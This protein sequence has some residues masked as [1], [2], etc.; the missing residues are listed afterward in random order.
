MPRKSQKAS[1]PAT[2][3]AEQ[4]AGRRI[5]SPW[6]RHLRAASEPYVRDKIRGLPKELRQELERRIED[7]DFRN[8]AELQSWLRA[9]GFHISRQTIT[10]YSKRFEA[11]LEALRIATAQ[12][13]AVVE[14]LKGDGAD[15][16]EAILRLV[17]GEMFN[18][19]SS[20]H[21]TRLE[22]AQLW[23]LSRTAKGIVETKILFKKWREESRAKLKAGV[24]A[25]ER[26]VAEA[27]GKGLSPEAAEEI[28]K[29]LLEI[30]V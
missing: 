24:G 2:Q 10:S 22:P 12:A 3:E 7:H 21:E 30:R 1:P 11:K 5:D 25:A 17:Q 20:L 9:K 16:D 8:F 6:T 23:T 26:K 28:R 19:L 27:R 29:A 4:V 18:L 14:G 15:F 13:R